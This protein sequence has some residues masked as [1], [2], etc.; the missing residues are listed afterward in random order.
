MKQT[1]S[2]NSSVTTLQKLRLLVA[3]PMVIIVLGFGYI[4][5]DAY[6]QLRDFEHLKQSVNTVKLVSRLIDR[7][8]L[9]RGVSNGYL[10]SGGEHFKSEMAQKREAV[11][12]A[13]A[14][15]EKKGT[16]SHRS[17]EAI[18]KRLQ[19]LRSAVMT[20]SI[21]PSSAF[22]VYTRIIREFQVDYLKL[23][24]SV[25]DTDIKTKLMAYTN[26]TYL[27]EALG[28]MRG[29]VNG[30]LSLKHPDSDLMQMVMSA[31]GEYIASLERARSLQEPY[32]TQKL[33]AIVDSPQFHYLA[34]LLEEM[35]KRQFDIQAIQPRE[36][37]EKSTVLI[38]RIYQIE[39]EYLH[40]IDAS[41]MERSRE[42]Y[43]KLAFNIAALILTTVLTLLL[44]FRLKNDIGRTIR[45]LEEYKDA[46]DRSNI[47]SKADRSGRITY[48]NDKFCEISGFSAEELIGKP[49]R[50]V[51]HVDT[52]K[53]IFDDMWKTILAKRPWRGVVKNRKK[54]GSDYI[55]EVTINP[56]VNNEGEIEEFI[57]IRHD[58]TEMLR[59]HQTIEQ[60]QQDL[61]YR[62]SEISEARSKETGFHVRRVAE[63]SR[64]LGKYSGLGEEEIKYLVTAS[65]MHDI[66]KVA[67]PDA[68]LNKE[69]PLDD[70]EREVM[71]RHASIGYD[72][73]KDSDKP[74]LKAAATIAH[75]HHERYD[76]KGYPSGLEGEE[77]HIYGRITALADVFDAL[78][79]ERCY[80]E[81]WPDEAIF[82]YLRAES[83]RQ[84]DPKLIEI[85]F[86]HLDD[87]LAVRDRYRDSC[88]QSVSSVS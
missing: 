35:Q 82:A 88:A 60:T 76:G 14:T 52:P 71:K 5:T 50:V 72:L 62:L 42:I 28:Q 77:I 51:R 23:L 63:Y 31:R 68:I 19:T 49:H 25:N 24:T 6:I 57:S 83:G 46:V 58:I 12:R 2:Q 66:G 32:Y 80:K 1:L 36:W 81:A 78:G 26:L 4:I 85:F 38:D 87:F 10:S 73:F 41:I 48:V 21:P 7:V 69:G 75:Q 15:L 11:D 30:L 27:K 20:R 34:S 8:Q 55:V 84:F 74:L 45:L 70:E 43:L 53:E 17:F 29:A 3:L 47:V 64:L 22:K 33:E 59:V 9:E 54:D 39:Q 65:P 56:I 16:L 79:S 18:E 44:A 67:I 86:K 61:I 13:L 40:E 37:F